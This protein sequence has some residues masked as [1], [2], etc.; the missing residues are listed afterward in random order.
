MK[1]IIEYNN[2]V[3][4]GKAFRCVVFLY[5]IVVGGFCILMFM[6]LVFG[7]VYISLLYIFI[8]GKILCINRLFC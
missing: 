6:Y 2:V 3:F 7:C 5:C 8:D 4:V 1:N